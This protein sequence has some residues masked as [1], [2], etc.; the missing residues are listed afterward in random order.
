M[1]P[2]RR[3]GNA[4][5]NITCAPRANMAGCQ[6]AHRADGAAARWGHRALP[7]RDRTTGRGRGRTATGPHEWFARARAHGNVAAQRDRTR[8]AA[9]GPRVVRTATGRGRGAPGVY[10]GARG[11]KEELITC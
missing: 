8:G 9:T 11:G 7:Q 2:S 10:A 6:A 3:P 1:S 4:R 5:A